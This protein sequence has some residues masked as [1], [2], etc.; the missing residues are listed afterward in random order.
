MIP[1]L[2]KLFTGA[3]AEIGQALVL[4]DDPRPFVSGPDLLEESRFRQV[5]A[6]FGRNYQ[7]PEP[8]AVATQWSKWHFSRLLTPVIAANIV[9]D[10][11]LPVGIDRIGIVLSPDSRTLAI[12]LPG[13]G[14]Q[15]QFGDA[16]D[17]FAVVIDKH[18]APLISGLSR[19]SGL[20]A[21]VLWSNAGN[22]FENVT[23]EC[24]AMLGEAHPGVMHARALL[25]SRHRPDKRR[26]ELFAPVTYVGNDAR[27]QRRI[28]CL[29]YRMDELSLCKSCPL[30]RVPTP[31]PHHG[32]VA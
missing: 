11:Q 14:D 6:D 5:L 30:E 8:M 22:V 2:A 26:N 1:A 12:R 16:H 18:L 3:F 29:R 24:A 19:A 17:R 20:P 32:A 7:S 15:R 9:A 25:I 21:K 28:C 31:K 23:K 27:R 10:R 13:E 4:S